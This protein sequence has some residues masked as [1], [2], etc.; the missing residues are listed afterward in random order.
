MVAWTWL[1][2]HR[3]DLG[4]VAVGLHVVGVWW[5]H[6]LHVHL[7]S[8]L[9]AVPHDNSSGPATGAQLVNSSQTSPDD[10]VEQSALMRWLRSRPWGKRAAVPSGSALPPQGSVVPILT[11]F[12]RVRTKVGQDRA[13]FGRHRRK[14][15]GCWPDLPQEGGMNDEARDRR[16]PLVLDSHVRRTSRSHLACGLLRWRGRNRAAQHVCPG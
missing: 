7:Q 2:P 1:M 13:G 4:Q 16:T 12:G 15:A 8:R 5:L 6:V 10:I 11:E 14:L 3:A 9:T